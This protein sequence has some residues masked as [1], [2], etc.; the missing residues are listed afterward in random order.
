MAITGTANVLLDQA[1]FDRVAYLALRAELYFDAVAEVKPTNQS[2]PGSSVVFEQFSDLAAATT[3][4]TETVD[5]TPATMGDAQ[6]TVTLNEYGNG[7]SSTAKLRGTNYVDIDD[8]AA[9]VIGY[10]AGLSVDT[11]ASD[12]LAAGTNVTYAGAATSRVTVAAASVMTGSNGARAVAR[13]RS[14]NVPTINGFYVAFIH[15]LVSYDLRQ[16]TGAGSWRDPHVY[17]QPGEI[18]TGEIGAFEGARYIE[19]PRGPLFVDA[20]VG[21]TV[22]VYR[23]MFVGRQALA[24]A[25]SAI[26]GNGPQPVVI[27]GPVVDSLRRFQPV[28]WYWLGG[29]GIFRQ[30][31]LDALESSSSLGAN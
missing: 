29:Y 26:D 5:I 14:R 8:I 27:R 13:L 31:S 15:P 16:A 30:A 22:D 11:V 4:L 10:N 3:P 12:I 9:N 21:G 20:G 24:K 6:V 28:G 1:A 23:T 25:W 18:W 7:V 19:T 17:S 2:M